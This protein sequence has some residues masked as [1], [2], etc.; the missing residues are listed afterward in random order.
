MDIVPHPTEL[1]RVFGAFPSGVTAVAALVDGVPVGL[2][3]SSF[4][5]VSLEPPLVSICIARTSS[6]WPRLRRAGRLGVSVLSAR[7]AHL[8]RQLSARGGDRFAG[9]TWRATHGGE[10]LLDGACAWLD[11]SIDREI[12]AGDHDI[13]LLRV[14]A[15]DADRGVPPLVFHQSRFGQ[16]DSA[17]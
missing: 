5:S 11:C 4:T 16:L 15:L 12:E 17:A 8:G 9:V 10:I 6:T 7:Q 13:V 1:R 3:A 14:H 2:A